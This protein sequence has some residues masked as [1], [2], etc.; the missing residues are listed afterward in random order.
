MAEVKKARL[1]LRRGTDTDRE[2]TTLCEGELGYSTDAFRVV[3]GDGTTAGGRSLGMTTFLTGG[4]NLS[5]YQTTLTEASAAG[6]AHKGD[7]ALFP[8]SSYVNA[9]GT[10][11]AAANSGTV[12]MLLTGAD[13]SAATASSW[14]AV[15]SGIPWGNLQVGADDISGD[16]IHGGTISGNVSFSGDIS[17]TSTVSAASGSFGTLIGTGVRQVVATATGL[18]STIEYDDS[19]AVVSN[20]TGVPVAMATFGQ[21][22]TGTSPT[23]ATLLYSMNIDSTAGVAVSSS[24]VT[25]NITALNNTIAI[26]TG[27]SPAYDHTG[28][29]V[30]YAKNTQ[31]TAVRLGGI[32]MITFANALGSGYADRP[33][34]ITAANYRGDNPITQKRADGAMPVTDYK[35][36]SSTTLLVV[37]SAPEFQSWNRK[38]RGYLYQLYPSSGVID[39]LTRF[40]VQVY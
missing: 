10:T 15:N 4:N 3:V 39:T 2:L 30:V 20:A 27:V 12:V 23:K 36:L 31:C 19:T 14:V 18:L 8:S 32:Y 21:A 22:G 6:Y 1:F 29:N 7:I 37:I 17:A 35:F 11:I 5:N 25:A 16:N 40:T 26:G 34:V 28:E 13:G 33:V 9:A 24:N 38:N